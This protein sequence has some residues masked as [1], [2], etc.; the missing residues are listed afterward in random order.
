MSGLV[1]KLGAEVHLTD[2]SGKVHVFRDPTEQIALAR[3]A[4]MLS[5]NVTMVITVE[6][7]MHLGIAYRVY[8][9]K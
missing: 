1:D 9:V 6:D 8:H 3:L 2:A 4:A 7:R 5:Q